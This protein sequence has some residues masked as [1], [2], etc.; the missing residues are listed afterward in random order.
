MRK[1]DVMLLSF[2]ALFLIFL[3]IGINY[4]GFSINFFEEGDSYFEIVVSDSSFN[5]GD[6]I[7]DLDSDVILRYTTSNLS[8]C[9]LRD[10]DFEELI[11]SLYFDLFNETI[12]SDL[13]YSFNQDTLNNSLNI[14]DFFESSSSLN[15]DLIQDLIYNISNKIESEDFFLISGFNGNIKDIGEV[16]DFFEKVLFNIPH[17][18]ELSCTDSDNPLN[19]EK[20]YFTLIFDVDGLEVNRFKLEP[21]FSLVD[22]FNYSF[23]SSI[24]IDDILTF[25]IV[26]RLVVSEPEIFDCEV[27]P[28]NYIICLNKS[29]LKPQLYNFDLDLVTKGNRTTSIKFFVFFYKNEN[30]LLNNSSMNLIEL[31]DINLTL[32]LSLISNF[33]TNFSLTSKSKTEMNDLDDKLAVKSIVIETDE[34]FNENLEW[35]IITLNYSKDDLP[36]NIN[37]STLKLYYYNESLK[38]WELI[39][40]SYVNETYNYIWANITHLSEYGIFGNALAEE[41]PKKYYRFENNSCSSVYLYYDELTD[42]DYDSLSKFKEQII[43]ELNDTILGEDD[44]LMNITTQSLERSLE[45]ASFDLINIGDNLISF[46]EVYHLSFNFQQYSFFLVNIDSEKKIASLFFEDLLLNIDLEEGKIFN[47]DL[48]GDDEYDFIFILSEIKNTDQINLIV[49][50]YINDNLNNQKDSGEIEFTLFKNVNKTLALIFDI[51]IGIIFLLS[52][53]ILIKKLRKKGLLINLKPNFK[54]LSFKRDSIPPE[55]KEEYKSIKKFQKKI[56]N[57]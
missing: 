27:S 52:L 55:D 40:N 38:I 54:N 22:D 19:N 8:S 9:Y 13:V 47:L 56:K 4:T 2:V 45:G 23:N 21:E 18:F 37:K 57:L 17:E 33:S 29:E 53:L 50:N 6:L 41:V 28:K 43:E 36:D 15:S 42:N 26:D 16:H 30:V 25:G 5:D 32:N 34:N 51:L 20:Y 7:L 48:N 49:E 39:Q 3:I 10:L 11:K 1:N 31:S 14:Y 46:D 35:A 12:N 24:L 44:S